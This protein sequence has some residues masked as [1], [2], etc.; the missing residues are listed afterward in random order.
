MIKKFDIELSRKRIPCIWECSKAGADTGYALV[1][2][3]MNGKTKKPFYVR[4]KGN[5]RALLPLRER[6]IVVEVFRNGQTCIVKLYSIRK[7]YADDRK[8]YLEA[9]LLN[10]YCDG[11]WERKGFRKEYLDAVDAAI[12]GTFQQSMEPVFARKRE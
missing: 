2:A 3:G 9:A 12:L 4:S 11:R 8:P 7:I 5:E 6:D 10:T 1:I